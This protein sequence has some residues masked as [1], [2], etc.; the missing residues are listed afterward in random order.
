MAHIDKYVAP[1]IDL[2]SVAVEQGFSN[3]LEDP[4]END[5]IDW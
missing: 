2:W 3:S 5:E 4:S 1:D